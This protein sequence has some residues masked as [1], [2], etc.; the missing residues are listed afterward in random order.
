MSQRALLLAVRDHLRKEFQWSELECAITYDGQPH[1]MCGDFFVAVYAGVWTS[2]RIEGRDDTFGV[3][4]TVSRRVTAWPADRVDVPLAGP[5]GEALDKLLDSIAAK[6]H[7]DPPAAGSSSHYPVLAL[8]N[9]TIGSAAN[10]FVEPLW[11]LDGG[12]PEPKGAD[13]FHADPERDVC[14]LAQT[15]TLGGA[16]RVQTAESQT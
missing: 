10:G 16:R 6:L 8:A 3:Q 1:P 15:L 9:A 11:L 12:R 4:V 7:G 2:A 14:G 13:W 5:D